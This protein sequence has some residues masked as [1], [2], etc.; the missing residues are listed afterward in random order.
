MEKKDEQERELNERFNMMFKKRD[1]MQKNIQQQSL[2]MSEKQNE[3][4]A[5]EDQINYL[6]V[7]KARLDAEKESL[8]IELGDFVGVELLQ[9]SVDN[10]DE[11]MKKAQES[12]Q[13]IG[14]VNMRA[15]E[16]YDE[17]KKEYDIVY[18]KVQ[19]L[20]KEKMEIL[21]IIEEI[22]KKKTRTFMKTFN[23]MND[24]FTRN[25]AQLYNKGTAHLELDNEDNIFEGGV[26]IIVKVGKGKYFD[27]T[28]L[29]GGEQT[30]V[31][32]ALLFAIQEYRPYHFYI[33]LR[34]RIDVKKILSVPHQDLN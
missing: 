9:G 26:N 18:D 16:A 4:R 6:N 27:V 33:L 24:L 13:Q 25:F 5:V 12:L 17:M 7:G 21:R 10:L 1:E 22:D 14:S 32:L 31:A 19:I 29:S 8:D 3:S 11:R 30:L 20:E 34:K 23:A 2:E 15:L 28:S